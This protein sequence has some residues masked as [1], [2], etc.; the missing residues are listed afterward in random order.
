MRQP[1]RTITLIA[2]PFIE[3]VKD[4]VITNVT[5]YSVGYRVIWVEYNE[6]SVL[7]V[8]REDY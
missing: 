5:S 8:N 7:A 1:K 4:L 3:G 6:N 2:K